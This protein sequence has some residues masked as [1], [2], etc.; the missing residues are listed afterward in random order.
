[1]ISS[2]EKT[3]GSILKRFIRPSARFWFVTTQRATPNSIDA[4]RVRLRRLSE[5]LHSEKSRSRFMF[6]LLVPAEKAQL[7][8]YR[9]D[10]KAYDLEL[11]PQLDGAGD[12][13][14]AGLWRRA[15]RME[16]RRT[17]PA[18]RLRKDRG[19]RAQGTA[20]TRSAASSW[21]AVKMTGKSASG[22]RRR[23][24]CRASSALPSAGPA[25]GIRWSTGAARRSPGMRR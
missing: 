16:D 15:G 18:R 17:R 12:R 20:A 13:A 8:R 4:S 5:Y 9:G 2:T 25:S 3:S 19:C 23:Q 7:E 22:S 10:K 14:A 11:R 6:E 21:D 24:A 1:M